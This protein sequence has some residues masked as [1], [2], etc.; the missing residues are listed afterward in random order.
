MSRAQALIANN[1]VIVVDPI[2]KELRPAGSYEEYE[3]RTLREAN[4]D[5]TT[6]LIETRYAVNDARKA[7]EAKRSGLTL[8]GGT[9]AAA[10]LAGAVG[11][12]RSNSMLMDVLDRHET[13]LAPVSDDGI[14]VS[15]K[16]ALRVI[17]PGVVDFSTV[18]GLSQNEGLE[19]A[20]RAKQA[21][22]EL[23]DS[24]E[25]KKLFTAVAADDDPVMLDKKRAIFDRMGFE[26]DRRGVHRL[27]QRQGAKQFKN[28]YAVGDRMAEVA[29]LNPLTTA[30]ALRYGG[31]GIAGLALG[32]LAHGAWNMMSPLQREQQQGRA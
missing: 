15:G 4:P 26:M 29:G 20:L 8:A 24:P 30:K 32:G 1:G 12:A 3:W 31:A 21:F 19:E 6:A 5:L 27:D 17:E 14:Y 18:K 10:G 22:R 9:L 11:Q 7:E 13:T 23:K 16:S 2:T 25:G 28:F